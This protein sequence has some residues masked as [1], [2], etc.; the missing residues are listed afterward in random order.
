MSSG[1]SSSFE[2]VVETVK[3]QTQHLFGKDFLK[4][5][6][7]ELPQATKKALSPIDSE[8]VHK[9]TGTTYR[10]SDGTLYQRYADGS[11]RKVRVFKKEKRNGCR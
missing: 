11:L 2:D 10:A 7:G 9:D 4:E 5:H 6:L 1:Y 8:K 3:E